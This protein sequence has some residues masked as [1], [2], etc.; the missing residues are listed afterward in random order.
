MPPVLKNP[1]EKASAQERVKL[2]QWLTA[3]GVTGLDR[4]ALVRAEDNRRDTIA[5]L[6]AWA[7]GRPK[8]REQISE[9][10]D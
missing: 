2:V 9:L 6:I 10:A 7:H 1:N 5:R 8:A 4:A 3:R